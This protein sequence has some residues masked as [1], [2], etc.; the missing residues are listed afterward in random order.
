MYKLISENDDHWTFQLT[1]TCFKSTIER[2]EKC[3]KYVQS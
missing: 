3:L 2:L 1:F